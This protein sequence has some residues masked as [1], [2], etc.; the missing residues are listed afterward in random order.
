MHIQDTGQFIAGELAARSAV[1]VVKK[2]HTCHP[3]RVL[4][5]C[6]CLLL[7]VLV[8]PRWGFFIT[9]YHRWAMHACSTRSTSKSSSGLRRCG[10]GEYLYR[11]RV[12]K[13]SPCSPCTTC[14]RSYTPAALDSLHTCPFALL[15]RLIIMYIPQPTTLVASYP[16]QVKGEHPHCTHTVLIL[17]YTVLHYT[18]T[19]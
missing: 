1:S 7:L 13:C 14:S 5:D 15:T 8:L 18:H 9:L 10:T 6:R 16:P 3:C 4:A 11:L 19:P 12:R 2:P 17:H